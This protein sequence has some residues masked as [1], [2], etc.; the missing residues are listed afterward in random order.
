MRILFYALAAVASCLALRGVRA[1]NPLD[2]PSGLRGCLITTS[3]GPSVIDI[4]VFSLLISLSG[5]ACGGALGG[6][7]LMNQ[8][9]K[10]ILSTK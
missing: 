1:A 8:K 5:R 7:D 2:F 9:E 4:W 3:L 10:K 6:D